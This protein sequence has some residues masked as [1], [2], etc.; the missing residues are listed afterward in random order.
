MNRRTLLAALAGALACAPL[1][2]CGR[3]GSV[4]PP[5]GSTYP[6]HYP[7]VRF[8]SEKKTEQPSENEP[9]DQK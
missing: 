9:E 4:I 1:A 3:R 6:R 2:A 7:N 8:P 5:E